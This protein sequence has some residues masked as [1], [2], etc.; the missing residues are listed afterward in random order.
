MSTSFRLKYF[1]GLI[2]TAKKID[3]DWTELFSMRNELHQIETSKELARYQE[4]KQLIQ[5]GDFQTKKREIINLKLKASSEYNVLTELTKLEKSKPIKDYFKYIQSPDFN[6]IN[7]IAESSELTRYFELKK[8]VES[9]DFISRKKNTES[10]RYKGSPEYI[11]RQEFNALQKSSRLKRYFAT[12]V[13][14]EYRLFLELEPSEKEK[15]NNHSKKKDPKLKI[16]RKFLNSRAY[17]NIKKVEKLGLTD[18]LEQLQKEIDTKSFYER[19]AFLKNVARFETTP[20]Y[21]LFNEFTKLSKSGDILFYLK[22]I[23]SSFYA[24]YRKMADSKELA[25]LKELRLQVE[26]PEFKQH[27][28]FLRNKR[29]YES[30]PEFKSETEFLELEKS[31]LITTYHQL[32]KRSEL[33]FFDQWEVVFEENFK[34]RQLATTL[35]EPENHWGSKMAGYSFSQVDELQAYKGLK[36]IEIR[37]EVLSIVTKAE[38][39]E[40]KVWDP[41]IGLIPKKFDY[42]SGILNTSN[43]FR[44]K[45]GVIEAKVKFRAEKAITSAFSLTGSKPFPQID[46]FRSGDNSVGLGIIDQPGNGGTKKLIQIKGLNFNN[47]H[48]FRLE[49]FGNLV[50]WKINNQEVHREQLN[51]NGSELFINFIGSLHHPINGTSLPHHFEIDWVRCL[52]KK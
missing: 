16:Y 46:V 52:R 20:D 40:G 32:K 11:K 26:V 4:L 25:R 43:S 44:F 33:A 6:R 10:L 31:Q 37:N 30:T 28:A 5:S 1:L 21:P 7:K 45:E 12:M 23:K 14:D 17:K 19:E 38:K 36:N 35:W 34:E 42:S 48:I 50:V 39:T 18:R 47:F 15:L 29:R 2:P 27:V 51:K 13:S 22:F 8:I 41:A 9:P 49:I 3:S 24:N